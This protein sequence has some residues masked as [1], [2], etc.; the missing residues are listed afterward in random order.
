M[1]DRDASWGEGR[2]PFSTRRVPDLDRQPQLDVPGLLEGRVTSMDGRAVASLTGE[3]DTAGA[4]A[5]GEFV[6]ALGRASGGGE[7]VIDLSGLTFID[8]TGIQALLQAESD[9]SGGGGR[10]V[11]RDPPEAITRL[12]SI[13][14]LA[15]VIAF[16]G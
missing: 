7:V 16:E 1:F 15:E 9:L 6:T 11:L 8:S 10:L 4:A 13:C 2:A 5:L 3:L 12:L 14:G